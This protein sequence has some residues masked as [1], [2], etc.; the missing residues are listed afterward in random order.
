ML[1]TCP[2]DLAQAVQGVWYQ[3]LPVDEY[4]DDITVGTGVEWQYLLPILSKCTLLRST[5]MSVVKEMDCNVRQW[6][7][8]AKSMIATIKLEITWIRTQFAR[9]SYFFCVGRPRFKSPI[10]QEAA[11]LKETCACMPRKVPNCHLIQRV[12][13]AAARVLNSRLA[14]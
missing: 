2:T 4:D 8:L 1:C 10:Q 6:D 13:E 3:I 5:A 9:Q 12:K 11:L 7:K 14:S